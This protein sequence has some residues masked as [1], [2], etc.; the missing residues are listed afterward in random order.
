MFD[1]CDFLCPS[2]PPQTFPPLQRLR[3]P[4][5]AVPLRPFN[6]GASK[7]LHA[8]TF[9]CA[10]CALGTYKSSVLVCLEPSIASLADGTSYKH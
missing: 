2:A 8:G 1:L 9:V 4:D 7:H 10:A 3:S 6:L 5:A